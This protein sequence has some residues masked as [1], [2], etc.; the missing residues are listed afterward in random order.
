MDELGH[1]VILA[2]ALVHG[3]GGKHVNQQLH[4]GAQQGQQ[5]GQ[6]LIGIDAG[7]DENVGAGELLV[8]SMDRDGTKVGYDLGLTRAIAD[9]VPVPVIASGGVGDLDD[10]VNG[11]IE[12]SPAVYSDMLVIGTTGKNTSYIYGIKIK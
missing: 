5:P 1:P 6:I 11:V 12:G 4:I 8:T 2:V 10:L 9:A 3:A 7:L